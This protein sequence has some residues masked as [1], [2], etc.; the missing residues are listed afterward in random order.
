MSQVVGATKGSELLGL[1]QRLVV[2]GSNFS[3]PN[4]F[5]V[6]RLRA[7]IDKLNHANAAEA[8]LCR[9]VLATACG[10][11]PDSQRWVLNARNLGMVWESASVGFVSASNLG[12]FGEAAA[13]YPSVVG[14]MSAPAAD[15]LAQGLICA[16]F[17]AL[18]DAVAP[19]Q[20]AKIE[21]GE[22][23]TQAVEVAMKAH[24]VITRLGVTEADVQAVLNVAGEVLRE[25]RLFWL[26]KEPRIDMID[27]EDGAALMYQ[28]RIGVDAKRA[29]NLT[30]EVLMIMIE[31]DLDK[32]GLCFSFLSSPTLNENA[33]SAH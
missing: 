8:S 18:I 11:W 6:R 25:H 9:A 24:A 17:R 4:S 23:H 32:P 15:H 13:M 28:F 14:V 26:D 27:D 29:N 10:D 5:E 20:R 21:I 30:D 33:D 16:S 31:R 3:A 22:L 7:E 1:T 2:E 12:Y 19:L